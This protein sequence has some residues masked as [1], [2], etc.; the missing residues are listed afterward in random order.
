MNKKAIAGILLTIGILSTSTLKS[1]STDMSFYKPGDTVPEFYSL[2]DLEVDDS[3]TVDSSEEVKDF[4]CSSIIV[5]ST[6]QAKDEEERK[7]QEEIKR[8][9]ERQEKLKSG[10]WLKDYGVDPG[11]LSKKR[12]EMLN[13]ARQYIGVPY[14]WG[15]TTPNGF[16]C[17]GYTKWV[18]GHV[19]G[20]DISR[21]T[22]TQI[23]NSNLR[24]VPK[25]EA[26]AGDI[27][28]SSSVDHTG[29]ILKNN[30]SNFT[31]LH[32]PRPGKNIKV[33][34]F[35]S[36]VSVYRLVGIDD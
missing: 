20:K 12:I 10:A 16:D 5:A 11:N 27:F 2:E 14:V 22:Y 36:N 3:E 33:G 31:I 23:N 13:Y 24:R 28:F 6:V 26:K 8:E 18:I 32:A 29:F 9:Q 4:Y 21:T 15:G 7:R 17:S 34:S 35:N 1:Y 19:F 25:S 30:G